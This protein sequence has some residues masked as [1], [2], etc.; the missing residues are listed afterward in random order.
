[1]NSYNYQHW[2]YHE[3]IKIAKKLD[4]THVLRTRTDLLISDFNRFLDIYRYIYI[5][6]PI[7]L[8]YYYHDGGYL[9]DYIYFFDIN[10]YDNIIINWQGIDDNRFSEK[11]LC[12]THFGTADWN[13]LKNLVTLSLKELLLNDIEIEWITPGRKGNITNHWDFNLSEF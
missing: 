1:M 7:F 11:Y 4:Y 8:G 10:F 9:I 2:Q 5:N 13:I 12:E 6:K 3:G